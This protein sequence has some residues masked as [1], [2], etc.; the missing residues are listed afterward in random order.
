MQRQADALGG[1]RVGVVPVHFGVLVA[2]RVDQRAGGVVGGDGRAVERGL[3]E[4][5]GAGVHGGAKMR[6]RAGGHAHAQDVLRFPARRAVEEFGQRAGAD[7][8]DV[9]AEHS[10][11]RSMAMHSASTGLAA[12]TVRTRP[13]P[14]TW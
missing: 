9:H 5:A 12:I 8:D 3:V 4:Q 1:G 7:G 6:G 13:A 14:W 11:I 10:S 2:D